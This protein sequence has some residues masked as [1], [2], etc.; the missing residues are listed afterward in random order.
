MMIT[1]RPATNQDQLAIR[2]LVRTERL[3]P[4]DLNWPNFVVAAG[5]RGLVG[6]VQLRIHTAGSRELGSLVVRKE[7]R[8]QG[9]ASRLIDALPC[10]S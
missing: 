10:K 2:A 7:A 6:A 8:G 5:E 9:I 1:I 3:N 4:T